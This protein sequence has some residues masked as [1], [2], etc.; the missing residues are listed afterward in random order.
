MA[1][2]E[3]TSEHTNEQTNERTNQQTN[4]LDGTQYLLAKVNNTQQL[5]SVFSGKLLRMLTV[6]IAI[7]SDYSGAEIL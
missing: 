7:N 1:G 5:H 3:L 2:C 6:P 4:K